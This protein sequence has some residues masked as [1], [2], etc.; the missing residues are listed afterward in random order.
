MY[1]EKFKKRAVGI[2]RWSFGIVSWLRWLDYAMIGADE[3]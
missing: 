1:I 2:N 3:S